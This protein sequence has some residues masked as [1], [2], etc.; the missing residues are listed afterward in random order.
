M[1][2]SNRD[3]RTGMALAFTGVLCLIL[4]P[5]IGLAIDGAVAYMM[6]AQVSRAADAAALA[7]ARSLNVGA[8]I[9]TQA[10]NATA[11]AQK[12]FTANLP[13]GQWGSAN[14]SSTVSVA[15]NNTTHLRSVT[16]TGSATVPLTFMSVLGFKTTQIGITATAQ[17]R[18]VNIMLV[19]DNSG[20][21]E[22]GNAMGPMITDATDFVNLF[23]GGRDQLGLIQFTGASYLAYAPSVNFKS[24]SPNVTTLIG[25]LQSVN[26]ATNSSQAI[27]MA[28]QQLKNLNQPGAFNVIVLFTDGLANTFTSNFTSLIPSSACQNMTSPVNGVLFAYTDNSGIVGL[29]DPVAK[30]LNDT[31]ESRPAPDSGSCASVFPTGSIGSYLTALPSTD[32]NG[33]STNGTGS[34]GPYATVNLQQV[35]PVNVTNAGLNALDD[36]AN[37]IRSDATFKPVIYTIG[38]GNNP[39]LPPDQ[40]LMARI[41]NDPTSAYFQP[42]QPQGLFVFSPTTAE[43]HSAFLRVA[44]EILRL[45]Q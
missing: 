12:Y 20:S 42:S 9:N 37:R 39:G 7:G 24:A 3:R 6:R 32:T 25:E 26:G 16:V 29:A 5:M 17:R 36:A 40:V 2:S 13:S 34:I 38:L 11:V 31:P 44:S 1:R 41:S 4:V 23:S 43:L 33:N 21:M 15:A 14:V 18:D 27:W 22:R 28:Y 30:T 8:D 35:T 45:A 19:L 10:A